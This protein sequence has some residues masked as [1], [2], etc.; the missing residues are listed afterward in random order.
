M[1]EVRTNSKTRDKEYAIYENTLIKRSEK[2]IQDMKDYGDWDG[3]FEKMMF[4]EVFVGSIDECYVKY[5]EFNTDLDD[6]FGENWR[7]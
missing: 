3:K 5:P 6:E 2:A 1:K 4:I 7:P